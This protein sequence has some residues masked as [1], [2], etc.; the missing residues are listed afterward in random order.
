M[1]ELTKDDFKDNG[2]RVYGTEQ[3]SY[4]KKANKLLEQHSMKVNYTD[5]NEDVEAKKYIVY[6]LQQRTVPQIIGID[7]NGEEHHIGGY[8]ELYALLK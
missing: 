1:D 4:C 7:N 6:D 3:C 8:E 2:F 5:I